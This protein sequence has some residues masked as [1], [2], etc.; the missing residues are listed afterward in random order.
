MVFAIKSF[1]FLLGPSELCQLLLRIMQDLFPQLPLHA[2][3]LRS[4]VSCGDSLGFAAL[5]SNP[6]VLLGGVQLLEVPLQVSNTLSEFSEQ[7][8]KDSM[9]RAG[10]NK[11]SL[12][13][14]HKSC[15]S[16]FSADA[17][18]FGFQTSK[19]AIRF[20][21]SGHFPEGRCTPSLWSR[22]CKGFC[23]VGNRNFER[24]T[25]HCGNLATSGQTSSG[26]PNTLTIF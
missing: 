14:P 7:G 5:E 16:H 26:Q 3:T 25:G 17:R 23:S 6:S 2:H 9:E 15:C 1:A 24:I 19:D 10:A 20:T 11:D 21:A 4:D 8:P 22:S 13:L 12:S 18:I